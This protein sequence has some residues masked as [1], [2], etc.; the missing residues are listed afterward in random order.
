MTWL[1]VDLFRISFPIGWYTFFE[2]DYVDV[3]IFAIRRLHLNML[4]L[5]NF[6]S[7]HFILVRPCRHSHSW[8]Q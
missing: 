3:D 4:E 1:V 8:E 5:D 2:F 7:F 6:C